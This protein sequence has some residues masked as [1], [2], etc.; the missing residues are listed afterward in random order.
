MT[1][2]A[3]TWVQLGPAARIY[4]VRLKSAMF[5]LRFG[6]PSLYYRGGAIE[7]Y[8]VS[9]PIIEVYMRADT[10]RTYL[11]HR[12]PGYA[13]DVAEAIEN[14]VDMVTPCALRFAPTQQPWPGPPPT[15]L[16]APS[17]RSPSGRSVYRVVWPLAEGSFTSWLSAVELGGNSWH[18]HDAESTVHVQIH[19]IQEM[20]LDT[21]EV[22][23]DDEYGTWI[24]SDHVSAHGPLHR[25][26]RVARGETPP[27]TNPGNTRW[28]SLVTVNPDNFHRP[29]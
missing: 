7:G 22:S 29:Y 28:H 23:T 11:V 13:A 16:V 1:T 9:D 26:Y 10:H 2:V 12:P 15:S 21:I 5:H 18:V 4:C 14:L 19:G 20:F 27:A 8:R 3:W 24:S 17:N 6:D 25:T